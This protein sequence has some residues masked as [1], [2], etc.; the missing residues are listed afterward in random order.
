MSLITKDD[1]LRMEEFNFES[2]NLEPGQMIVWE[3]AL[4]HLKE[5]TEYLA[6]RAKF[7]GDTHTP[8]QF[9]E[10]MQDLTQRVR[11]IIRT[12]QGSA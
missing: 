12:S 10:I 4:T 9:I 5:H 1:L 11:Q 2:Y 8:A 3:H 6:D 7:H